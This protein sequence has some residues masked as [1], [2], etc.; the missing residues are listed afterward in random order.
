MLV[1]E[2]N[3][4]TDYRLDRLTGVEVWQRRLGW[5][6]LATDRPAGRVL[7]S[8][9]RTGPSGSMA[10]NFAHPTAKRVG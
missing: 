8:R 9:S 3:G 2:V 4:P 7:A 10:G 6:M 5:T 1:I